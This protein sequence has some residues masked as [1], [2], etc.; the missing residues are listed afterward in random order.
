MNKLWCAVL[1]SAVC[2][3]SGCAKDW[4]SDDVIRCVNHVIIIDVIDSFMDY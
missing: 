4:D 3:L 1:V 2:L